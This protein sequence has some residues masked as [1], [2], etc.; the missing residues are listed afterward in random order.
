MFVPIFRKQRCFP[1]KK[2]MKSVPPNMDGGGSSR[3]PSSL[4]F[5][6]FFGLCL[7]NYFSFFFFLSSCL[8]SPPLLPVERDRAEEEGEEG[9]RKQRGKKKK[10]NPG[11]ALLSSSKNT[12]GKY[13]REGLSSLF[14]FA[15]LFSF[16]PPISTFYCGG[17]HPLSHPPPKKGRNC[18]FLASAVGALTPP[19]KKTV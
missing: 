18:I 3:R 7:R 10:K 2:K 9:K 11:K 16:R 15:V 19:P 12:A 8:F 17:K 6:P 4:S 1:R 5:S 14:Y 13:G